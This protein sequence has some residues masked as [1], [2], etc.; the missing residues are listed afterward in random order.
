MK[1]PND[2]QASPDC[3][4]GRTILITGAGDG[5]GRTIAIACA[6]HGAQVILLGKTIKKLESVYDEIESS[7]SP[8]PAIFPLNLEGATAADYDEMA[9]TL[10]E[11]FGK[12]DGILHNA[13]SLPYLSR[14]KDYDAVDWLKVM[15]VNV[16]APF[17]ITQSCFELLQAS[18]DASVLFTSDTV[19]QQ[20][21]PF[22]GAYGASKFAIESLAETWASEVKSTN[23]RM[24]LI[25]PGATLTALRKRIFPGE[26]NSDLKKTDSLISMYL[27]ALGGDSLGTNGQRIEY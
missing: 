6:K 12:L 11:N 22:W 14:L 16:N 26:E 23:I 5:I 8:Q 20:S 25:D 2:Y 21:K 15:Q 13:A 1:I 3:L 7:G 10:E 17:L 18:D 19:G 24:N 27:W 4:K 9:Q